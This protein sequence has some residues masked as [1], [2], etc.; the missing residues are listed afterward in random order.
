MITSARAVASK[1]KAIALKTSPTIAKVIPQIAHLFF[2]FLY[3][4]IPRIRAISA[5]TKPAIEPSKTARAKTMLII[6]RVTETIPAPL[7]L[8]GEP[9]FF[10][11]S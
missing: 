5:K 6:P 3:W 9:S 2:D 11:I 7:E 10:M 4:K 8:L 1:Y